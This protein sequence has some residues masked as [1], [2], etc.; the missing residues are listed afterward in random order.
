[1]R[2]DK[3]SEFVVIKIITTKSTKPTSSTLPYGIVIF[4]SLMMVC[5]ILKGHRKQ[6]DGLLLQNRSTSFS[7]VI[8][9]LSHFTDFICRINTG[10][11]IHSPTPI[12]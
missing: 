3:C 2:K 10:F 11:W 4:Y 7:A 9:I 1:M 8:L 5:L 6:N 12:H